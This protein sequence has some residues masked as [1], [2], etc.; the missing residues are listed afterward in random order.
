[1]SSNFNKKPCRFGKNC[2]NK[3]TCK[4]EHEEIAPTTGGAT[5]SEVITPSK[6]PCRFGERCRNKSTCKFVH[7]EDDDDEEIM[8]QY[9][10]LFDWGQSTESMMTSNFIY[11]M[12]NQMCAKDPEL[13]ISG[14]ADAIVSMMKAFPGAKSME[15]MVTGMPK[16]MVMSAIA[17]SIDFEIRRNSEEDE[18]L[19]QQQVD[20]ANMMAAAGDEM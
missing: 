12:Y 4:F 17:W 11:H 6:K 10:E 16:E 3:S 2:R 19:A 8:E 13:S 9:G 15:V 20:D 7:D 1:M 5:T 18:F 14:A